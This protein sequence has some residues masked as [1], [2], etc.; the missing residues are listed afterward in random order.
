MQLLILTATIVCVDAVM[1]LNTSPLNQCHLLK[2]KFPG[3]IL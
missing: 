3:H 2:I 1:A